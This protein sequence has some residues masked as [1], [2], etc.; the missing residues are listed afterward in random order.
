[1]RDRGRSGIPP[2]S[3]DSRIVFHAGKISAGVPPSEHKRRAASRSSVPNAY[4]VL[5]WREASAVRLSAVHDSTSIG[6]LA[7]RGSSARFSNVIFS[8]SVI[9]P[10]IQGGAVGAH[11]D[12]SNHEVSAVRTET[13][14]E[15]RPAGREHRGLDDDGDE[16]VCAVLALHRELDGTGERSATDPH[17][18]GLSGQEFIY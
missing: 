18:C 14:G 13:S 3:F 7:I 17:A 5:P 15:G 6:F 16:V 8:F 2:T 1:M 12:G 4:A 10:P 11:S 9:S